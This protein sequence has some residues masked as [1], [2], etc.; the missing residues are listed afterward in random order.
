M[1][2]QLDHNEHALLKTKIREFNMD[3]SLDWYPYTEF[4]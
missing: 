2:K 4:T 3:V 1:C